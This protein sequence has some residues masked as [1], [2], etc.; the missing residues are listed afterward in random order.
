M[1]RVEWGK[2][3][4]DE[5][6]SSSSKS[7]TDFEF[8]LGV[9]DATYNREELYEKLLEK[10]M[11]KEGIKRE[12]EM[13]TV[14]I[15]SGLAEKKIN[16]LLSSYR[17]LEW[18]VGLVGRYDRE[19]EAYFVQDVVVCEQEVSGTSVELTK[20]GNK[21]LAKI[22]NII[23]W[24][25][26]HNEM[27][28][29]HSSTDLGTTAT[30]GLGMTVNN[31]RK[32]DVKIRK[33]LKIGLSVLVEGVVVRENDV[34]NDLKDWIEDAKS[35]IKETSFS[36]YS[37][38]NRGYTKCYSDKEETARELKENECNWCFNK[39]PRSRVKRGKCELCAVELHKKCMRE[40]SDE[41]K[42]CYECF[43]EEESTS[44]G[45]VVDREEGIGYTN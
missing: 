10:F 44:S 25:H 3:D 6:D 40:I 11:D 30:F 45:F 41:G 26:S 18:T 4:L 33:D 1:G 19:M 15:L 23:G 27:D 36:G 28:S 31:K 16:A 2:A 32:F 20:E 7:S 35:K 39:L 5:R 9:I 38:S 37:D 24:C 34:L 21:E 12:L 22:R 14:V 13:G 42:L 29:F 8:D 43:C 17:K